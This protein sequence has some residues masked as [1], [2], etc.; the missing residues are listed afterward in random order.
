M[1]AVRSVGGACAQAVHR[2][3]PS[4][5]SALAAAWRSGRCV[6][7]STAEAAAVAGTEPRPT[8]AAG[9]TSTASVAATADVAI[10]GAGIVGTGVALEL[11][12]RGLSS[13]CIDKTSGPGQGSTSFSSGICRTYYS[14]LHSV[15]FSYEGYRVW[16]DWDEYVGV[17]DDRGMARLR[18]CGGMILKSPDAAPFL[19]KTLPLHDQ[20]RRG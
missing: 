1:H 17:K 11:A 7:T 4:G 14:V 18:E 9:S 19:A 15:Q 8:G 5:R 3:A 2:G 12:R 20:V 6:H 13:V 16:Q 10:I